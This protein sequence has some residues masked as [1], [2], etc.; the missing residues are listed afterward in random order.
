MTAKRVLAKS[1]MDLSIMC[2]RWIMIMKTYS[3]DRQQVFSGEALEHTE[4][5]LL[6]QT[7]QGDGWR[8]QADPLSNRNGVAFWAMAVD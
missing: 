8:A 5:N 1:D 3:P 4:K 2:G 6:G 7:Q